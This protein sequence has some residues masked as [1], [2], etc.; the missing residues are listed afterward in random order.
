M[1]KTWN[2]VTNVQNSRAD[3]AETRPKCFMKS[4]EI[5]LRGNSGVE[6]TT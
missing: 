1:S 5:S 3:E 6:E 2:A 4:N